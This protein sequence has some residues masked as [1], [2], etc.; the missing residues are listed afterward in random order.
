MYFACLTLLP[1]VH[2]RAEGINSQYIYTCMGIFPI[3]LHQVN[4][5]FNTLLTFMYAPTQVS[6]SY[7]ITF[8]NFVFKMFSFKR[9]IFCL[10]KR[11][12]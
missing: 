7:C 8:I 9:L 4:F 1:T 2:S 5:M 12:N 3:V 11:R 10:A 6:C